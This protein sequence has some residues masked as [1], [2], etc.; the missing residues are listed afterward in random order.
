VKYCGLFLI[1]NKNTSKSKL[2]R[3][4]TKA[5]RSLIEELTLVIDRID[6]E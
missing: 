2:E 3:W 5:K 4:N 6:D 1:N